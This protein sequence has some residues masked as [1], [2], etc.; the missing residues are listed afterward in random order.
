MST[1]GGPVFR[2]SLQGGGVSPPCPPSV[3]PLVAT[4]YRIYQFSSV[5]KVE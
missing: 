3:T 4:L 5:V 2:F 1:K